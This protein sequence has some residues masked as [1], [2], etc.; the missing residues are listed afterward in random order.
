MTNE[1]SATLTNKE[2][3]TNPPNS[4][5]APSLASPNVDIMQ[6]MNQLHRTKSND[7]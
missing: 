2:L 3:D 4:E 5:I 7:E 1:T 6:Q